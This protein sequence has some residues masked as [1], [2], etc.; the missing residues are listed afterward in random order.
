VG[1]EVNFAQLGEEPKD[2]ALRG[3]RHAAGGAN[4][5]A[6]HQGGDD[7]D[8]IFTAHVV[9]EVNSNFGPKEINE[10]VRGAM[11]STNPTPA[12]FVA[13]LETITVP[14]GRCAGTGKHIRAVVNGRPEGN[15]GPCFRCDGKGAQSYADTQ[16]NFR[17]DCYAIS[18]SC[19]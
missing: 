2:G 1:V 18:A 7:A 6:L 5:V 16:R 11:T 4:G 13:T 12:D 9:H 14:C 3:A 15:G 8:T 10:I 19:T 17:Y